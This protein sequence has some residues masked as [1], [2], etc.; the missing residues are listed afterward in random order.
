[1]DIVDAKTRSRM[2]AAIR[3]KDTLPELAVRRYLH[4]AGLRFVKHPAKLPGR[5]D[6]VLSKYRMAVFVHGCFWHR[7]AGCRFTT[8]PSTNVDS[9]NAKFATNERRD[10]MNRAELEQLGWHVE[11]VWEC[12][13]WDEQRLDALVWQA[14]SRS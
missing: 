11:V 3:G 2:M 14:F 9:W 1:M 8:T 10:A 5:P 7:H 4:A 6:V 12:E 13:A